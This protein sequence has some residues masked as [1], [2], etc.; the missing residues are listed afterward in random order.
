MV[1][2]LNVLAVA[3]TLLGAS[4]ASGAPQNHELSDVRELLLQDA[5]A[6]DV[7][8]GP[9]AIESRILIFGK[10]GA[11]S[12]CMYDDTGRHDALGTWALEESNGS[13]VLVLSG[14]GLWDKGRYV[15]KRVPHDEAIELRFAG[16]ERVLRF[17]RRKG[18]AFPRPSAPNQ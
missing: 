10:E 3:M 14:K 5:W 18:Y 13:V 17:E 15:V 11:V 8:S 4:L 9:I 7:R 2:P 6:Y 16:E 12:E 1:N